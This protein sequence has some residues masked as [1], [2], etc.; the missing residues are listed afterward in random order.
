MVKCE[1]VNPIFAKKD[2]RL[3]SISRAILLNTFPEQQTGTPVEGFYAEV[4]GKYLEKG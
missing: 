4:V 2:S 1:M 3:N